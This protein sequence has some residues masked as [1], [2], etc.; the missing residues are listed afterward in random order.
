MFEAKEEQPMKEKNWKV[1]FKVSYTN[2]DQKEEEVTVPARTI[3]GALRYTQDNILHPLRYDPAVNW[4]APT[5]I[6]EEEEAS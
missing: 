4:A 2:G 6:I 1:T 3:Q 5:R